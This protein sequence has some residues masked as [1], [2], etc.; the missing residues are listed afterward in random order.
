MVIRA[1]PGE[2]CVFFSYGNAKFHHSKTNLAQCLP[3]RGERFHVV[4]GASPFNKYFSENRITELLLWAN[5]HIDFA[6]VFVPD[7]P[8]VWTLEAG[9][10]SLDE[11][12]HKS[13][14]QVR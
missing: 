6:C 7:T 13:R 12:L 10:Y 9:D 1:H 8:T 14:R 5:D 4:I 11:A 3:V 2:G